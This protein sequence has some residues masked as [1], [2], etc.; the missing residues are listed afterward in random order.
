MNPS[1]FEFYGR[2]LLVKSHDIKRHQ[3]YLHFLLLKSSLLELTYLLNILNI[4][5]IFWISFSLFTLDRAI[6]PLYICSPPQ[7]HESWL[8]GNFCAIFSYEN[9]VILLAFTVH[10]CK[11]PIE[12]LLYSILLL[13]FILFYFISHFGSTSC[14]F[15]L[16]MS[17]FNPAGRITFLSTN[18]LFEQSLACYRVSNT[19]SPWIFILEKV[20]KRQCLLQGKGLKD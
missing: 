17:V 10:K 18:Q 8:L 11:K 13:L 5:I 14:S 9:V 6:C 4:L 12:R 20:L 2:Q 3:T 1:I 7:A 16:C 19:Y 15:P